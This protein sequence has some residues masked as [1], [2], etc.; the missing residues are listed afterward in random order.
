[1]FGFLSNTDRAIT[2]TKALNFSATMVLEAFDVIATEA[3]AGRPI[4]LTIV[5][6]KTAALHT[7]DTEAS[8][9]IRELCATSDVGQPRGPPVA[10]PFS[11]VTLVDQ[12]ALPVIGPH[13]GAAPMAV[14]VLPPF[15]VELNLRAGQ[16]FL[17]INDTIIAQSATVRN[18]ARIR[19]KLQAANL[20]NNGTAL[21]ARLRENQLHLIYESLNSMLPAVRGRSDAHR[22]W[23][24]HE[25]PDQ[26]APPVPY[27]RGRV[28]RSLPRDQQQR[29]PVPISCAS[30]ALLDPYPGPSP[31]RRTK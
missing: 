27:H 12:P 1:M 4:N 7:D 24:R 30:F 17:L 13:G 16:V 14:G 5:L 19:R 6:T 23:N 18:I 15:M 31:L 2:R 11:A 20:D 8:R 22:Y 28:Q 21:T 10:C 9:F 26:P 29:H 3:Q 25:H